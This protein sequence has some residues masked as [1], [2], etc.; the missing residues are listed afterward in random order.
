[1]IFFFL[2]SN[3]LRSSWI[4]ANIKNQDSI[5]SFLI[6]PG[7]LVKKKVRCKLTH[8]KLCRWLN[9]VC[10]T[11]TVRWL[12]FFSA[13]VSAYEEDCYQ[14]I[15]C[16]VK[17]NE[18]IRPGDKSIEIVG[19]EAMIDSVI[20]I[21]NWFF[22]CMEFTSSNSNQAKR[23][24][25]LKTFVVACCLKKGKKRRLNSHVNFFPKTSQ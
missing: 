1:M 12:N 15:R 3:F 4:S 20:A 6:S 21:E 8:Q 5:S 22:C 7:K 14:S 18:W 13:V 19:S 2:V 17:L 11:Y 10:C 9:N 23:K 25:L 16:S 24:V